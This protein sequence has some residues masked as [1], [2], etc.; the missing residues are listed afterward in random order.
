[1]PRP[2]WSGL[3]RPPWS[4]RAGT[5]WTAAIGTGRSPHGPRDSRRRLE[6]LARHALALSPQNVVARGFAVVRRPDG[7]V[8][9][10]PEEVSAGELLELTVARGTLAAVAQSSPDMAKFDATWRAATGPWKR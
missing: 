3:S 5:G 1:M 10:G 2:A 9:R 8:V 6:R 7:T 4:R